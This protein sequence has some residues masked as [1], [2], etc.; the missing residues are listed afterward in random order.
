MTP[1]LGQTPYKTRDIDVETAEMFVLC[2]FLACPF[3]ASLL[4]LLFNFHSFVACG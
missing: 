4:D 3:I 1:T 2:N